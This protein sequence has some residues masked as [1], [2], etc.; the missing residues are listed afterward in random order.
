M[1]PMQRPMQVDVAV[2]ILIS[3]GRDYVDEMTKVEAQICEGLR[4]PNVIQARV[5]YPFFIAI[6]TTGNLLFSFSC[7]YSRLGPFSD[8]S[9]SKRCSLTSLD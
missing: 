4:H 6:M 5:I 9:N 1:R 3:N 2:K 8:I 7:K